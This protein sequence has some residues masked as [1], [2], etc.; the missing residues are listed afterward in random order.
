M[1]QHASLV[2]LSRQHIQGMQKALDLITNNGID[3]MHTLTLVSEL[4]TEFT[5]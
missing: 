1:R 4:S 3:A 2:R 5:K